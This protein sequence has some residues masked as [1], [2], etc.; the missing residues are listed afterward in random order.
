MKIKVLLFGPVR[1]AVGTSEEVIEFPPGSTLQDVKAH[2]EQRYA[3]VQRLSRSILL[4][5]NQHFQEE[6]HLIDDGDE[7]ALLPPVSG[8]SV[9]EYSHQIEEEA[10]HFFA[11][12]HQPID[13]QSLIRRALRGQDGAVVSFLGTVRDHSNGRRTRYLDYQCYESMAIQ[14]M[15]S[16][17]REIASAHAVDRMVMVHRLGTMQIGEASVA[18]VVTSAHRKP[19]FDACFEAI[20]RLKKTVPIWKKEYFEDGEVWVEGEWD[21]SLPGA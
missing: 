13:D 18:I 1:D 20:N 11:L 17:G 5:C 6:G 21:E 3:E 12:T 2:Y 19:A 7:V 16:L 4:A 14:V 8:G 15:A 9:P 10:G